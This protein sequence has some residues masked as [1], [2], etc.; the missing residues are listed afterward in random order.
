MIPR[1]VHHAKPI[2]KAALTL[3]APINEL[4]SVSLRELST[5]ENI[6]RMPLPRATKTAKQSDFSEHKSVISSGFTRNQ[7]LQ[8]TKHTVG[9]GKDRWLSG[10]PPCQSG[11]CWLRKNSLSDDDTR[12]YNERFSTNPIN[13]ERF[14]RCNWLFPDLARKPSMMPNSVSAK[15]KKAR[16][17]GA[18]GDAPPLG[19]THA[20]KVPN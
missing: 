2:R 7:I 9:T 4:K 8:A 3:M 6:T 14:S 5:A 19:D 1:P 16:S 11:E 10:Q 20:V 12:N 15:T 17:D 18:S 13:F